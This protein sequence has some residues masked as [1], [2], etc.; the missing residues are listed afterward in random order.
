MEGEIERFTDCLFVQQY[1]TAYFLKGNGNMICDRKIGDM[2]WFLVIVLFWGDSRL[3]KFFL[4]GLSDCIGRSWWYMLYAAKSGASGGAVA[5]LVSSTGSRSHLHFFRPGHELL[6]GPPKKK[7]GS[8][9]R[10]R[11]SLKCFMSWSASQGH[12]DIAKTEGQ[13]RI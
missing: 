2:M 4:G 9:S 11:S 13:I 12:Y 1:C 5:S 6:S 7:L 3:H 8:I 10:G